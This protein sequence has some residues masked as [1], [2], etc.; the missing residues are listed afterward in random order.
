MGLASERHDIVSQETHAG[1]WISFRQPVRRVAMEKM[2]QS[3]DYTWQANPGEVWEET[4]FWIELSW[5][6]DPDGAMGIRKSFESPYRPGEKITVHEYFQWMF[7]NTVP[8][9]PE[10]AAEEGLTALEF[11][12]KYGAFALRQGA[13]RVYHQPVEPEML[14]EGQSSEDGASG[15]VYT[16]APAGPKLDITPMPAFVGDPRGRPVGIRMGEDVLRGFDTPS[17]KLE[18]YSPTLRD[19]GWP[20]YALP[21]YIKSQVHPESL[22]EAA[23]ERVLLPTF[24]LPT[25]IHTRSGNSKWLYE[26]SHK[27]PLWVHP[28]DAAA[29]GLEAGKLARVSTSI[30]YFVLP[31]WVTEG[32]RPGVV[33]CSHHL[34]RWR[35]SEGGGSHWSSNRVSLDKDEAAGWRMRVV[36]PVGPFESSDPDSKRVWWQDVG[37]HQNLCFGVQPDPVSGMHCWHQKVRVGPAEPGD[38][39]GDVFA[40]TDRAHAVYREW[41]AMA[42]SADEVSPDGLRRPHWLLRPFRPTLEAYR[43]PE[44]GKKGSSHAGQD[45]RPGLGSDPALDPVSDQVSDHASDQVSDQVAD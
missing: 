33:A 5:R 39:H 40:D 36:E 23:G 25:L 2:G 14:A 29:L 3:F 45:R 7:E 9:L 17:R 43:L 6:I 30:G 35:L 31:V 1:C 18:F 28:K 38:R 41:L 24:R 13:E 19:W 16:Q 11:M 34:G 4:E 12:R 10:K 44:D 20:E 42:R 37:V 32:I 22:D 8:G 21:A 27:N 15:I 26:I